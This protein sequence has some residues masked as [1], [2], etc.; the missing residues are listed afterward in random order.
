MRLRHPSESRNG[1]NVSQRRGEEGLQLDLSE[2]FY[3]CDLSLKG[4]NPKKK[5]S[6]EE[7]EKRRIDL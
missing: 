4:R 2:F 1:R 5:P 3:S 7:G 6:A